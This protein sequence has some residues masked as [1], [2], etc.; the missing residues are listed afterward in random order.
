VRARL[1]EGSGTC[2]VSSY[3]SIT[4]PARNRALFSYL[5]LLK[6]EPGIDRDGIEAKMDSGE[7]HLRLPVSEASRTKR[8]EVRAGYGL[9]K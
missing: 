7:L 9:S 8:I 5:P 4:L 1:D 3:I 6:R 2:Q